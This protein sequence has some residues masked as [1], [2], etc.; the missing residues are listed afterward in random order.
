MLT[1]A[2]AS[3]ASRAERDAQER[4]FVLNF[5]ERKYWSLDDIIYSHTG[6]QQVR[7]RRRGPVRQ[8]EPIHAAARPNP[9]HGYLSLHWVQRDTPEF[10]EVSD[11]ARIENH[12]IATVLRVQ[13][14]TLMDTFTQFM[15][16]TD[17][18]VQYARV[19]FHSTTKNQFLENIL[20]TGLN[21]AIADGGMFGRGAYVGADACI[22]LQ[23]YSEGIQTPLFLDSA[24]DAPCV[25]TYRI[26]LLFACNPGRVCMYNSNIDGR[27][28]EGYG[29]FVDK[30][31]DPEIYCLQE[32]ERSCPAY[33]LICR[34]NWTGHV[35]QSLRQ[36]AL[37]RFN[38][39]Y[40]L[41]TSGKWQWP[42][43]TVGLSIFAAATGLPDLTD[44]AAAATRG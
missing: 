38:Q 17:P 43:E 35:L 7:H 32:Y 14:Y 11:M 23:G 5:L 2:A 16:Q 37:Q 21:P 22:S 26:V 18:A 34:V 8:H 4:A 12:T 3:E 1:T 39:G 31:C 28:P 13:N 25:D 9:T 36:Q 42:S 19:G 30:D 40:P 27:I 20:L 15:Q 24:T 41:D 6:L 33:I 10:V 29:A 44:R